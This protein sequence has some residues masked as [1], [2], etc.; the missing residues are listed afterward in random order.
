MLDQVTAALRA[1]VAQGAFATELVCESD[2]LRVEVHGAGPL[3]FPLSARAARQLSEVA[4]LAPFGRRDKTLS[5][6]SVRNT[7]EIDGRHVK[8]DARAWNR[9]LVPQLAV[10]RKRLGL[11]DDGELKASFDKL[12]V[13]G[14]GQFFAP[15][16]DSERA[17]DMVAT[18]VVLLPSAASGGALVVAHQGQKKVFR[19]AR[20]GPKDLALI[21]FYADCHHEVRPVK[22]GYRVALTYQ[23]HYQA[24]A[25]D[26]RPSPTS[27][28]V[29]RL[30]RAIK[31][32]FS[33]PPPSPRSDRLIYL[34]DHE[35]TQKSLS[36]ERLKNADRLRVDAV[37]AVG[38]VRTV[39][40]VADV[41]GG[42]V[43]AGD[44]GGA[45]SV[46]LHGARLSVL[47]GRAGTC[48]SNEACREEHST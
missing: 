35:Y 11:P 33:G 28:A 6:L 2:N 46:V 16:Q 37:G 34:L 1:I 12:L 19:G 25:R 47:A 9:T 42:A 13:Y 30:A 18:L 22:S 3:R 43:S 44:G 5:D 48:G 23:L 39:G 24:T 26:E 20:R 15:H 21:A 29:A 4:Q 10:L 38:A 36:F 27:D 32:Y 45:V 7:W 14:P 31:A 40:A 8:I 17:D 41:D